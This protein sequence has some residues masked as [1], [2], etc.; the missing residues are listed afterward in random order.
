M[1]RS[2]RGA[3]MVIAAILMVTL[4]ASIAIVIDAG[5]LFLTKKRLQNA[6]DASALAGCF[7]LVNKQDPVQADA[8]SLKYLTA[9]IFGE[10]QYTPVADLGKNTFQVNISQKVKH[11]FAPIIGIDNST[12]SAT[13]TAG[14]NTVI[15]IT[16]VVPL[17]VVR[18][19]FEFNKP[20][21]LKYGG[22]EG[23]NGNY[24]ALALGGSGG[25]NYR[26]NLMY[27][28]KNKIR[29]GDIVTAEPGNMAG[30]TS[31]GVNYRISL[32]NS[33]I[34][35]LAPNSPRV[36]IVPV[37]DRLVGDGSNASA[38][39]VSF[40]AFYLESTDGN[41]GVT[42]SFLNWAVSGE[43]GEGPSFGVVS[44]TLIK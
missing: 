28:Y 43:V 41:G 20:Y 25:S 40:A 39:V 7:V 32:D 6:A 5:Q 19:Q 27:G 9:N 21:T 42:G 4:M 16:G 23:Y 13:A 30:P 22:G 31:Q 36:V 3:V 2:E 8:E 14:G 29:L 12:V 18:Q 37:I 35:N 34:S 38:M 17:G 11:F 24:G 15:S 10:Y 26:S 1:I 33:S 44:P